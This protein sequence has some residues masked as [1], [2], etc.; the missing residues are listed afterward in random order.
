MAREVLAIIPARG[1]SKGIPRKNLARLNGRPL[2]AYTCRQA[3][4]ARTVTRVILSSDDPAIAACARRCGVDVPF[5]RPAPLATDATPMR[6]VIRHALSALRRREGYRPDIIVVL[7]PTSP[8]RRPGDIDGAV[9]LLLRRRADVV[10][11]VV[12]APHQFRP[13][14]LMRLKAG[15]LVPASPGRMVLRR[16]DKS[17]AYARNGPAVLVMRRAV[18]ERGTSLYDGVCVP[19]VMPPERSVDIDRS[20]D[21]AVAQVLLSRAR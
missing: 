13:E 17:M 6:D 11:S 9:R 20:V 12:E 5:L 10:V 14:S 19:F 7:Q 18:A 21:M 4:A 8:L 3:L 1:G 15:R 16:Q 2:L